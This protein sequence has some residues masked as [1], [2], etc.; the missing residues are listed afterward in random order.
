MKDKE[1]ILVKKSKIERLNK[2]IA[3]FLKPKYISIFG[4][5]FW[6]IY[7]SLDILQ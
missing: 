7:K 5:L 4:K 2:Q 1:G 3:N 6:F